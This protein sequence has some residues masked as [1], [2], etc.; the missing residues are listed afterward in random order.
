[1]LL[2]F[3]S[4]PMGLELDARAQH[5]D[6]QLA[7]ISDEGDAFGIPELSMGVEVERSLVE[8]LNDA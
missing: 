2:F 3:L 5:N 4:G 6:G 7:I 1:L 8:V